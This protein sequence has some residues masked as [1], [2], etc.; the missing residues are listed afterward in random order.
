MPLLGCGRHPIYGRDREEENDRAERET[1]NKERKKGGG[2]RER[3]RRGGG[4]GRYSTRFGHSRR[5][6]ARR[7]G[8]LGTVRY[9]GLDWSITRSLQSVTV[10][11]AA[12]T[13]GRAFS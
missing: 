12:R 6:V 11:R 13:V 5:P 10:R 7:S 8:V 1:R 4:R 9:G 2:E 3:E